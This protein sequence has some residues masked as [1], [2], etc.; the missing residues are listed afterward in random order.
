[1]PHLSKS[2]FFKSQEHY[3][4]ILKIHIKYV[5]AK[6]KSLIRKFKIMSSISQNWRKTVHKIILSPKERYLIE[7]Y[8]YYILWIYKMNYF[9][10]AF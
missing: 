10:R 2:Y 8:I 4:E 9:W 5:F 6:G 3:I 7:I 1:M